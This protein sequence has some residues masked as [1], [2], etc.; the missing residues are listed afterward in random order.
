MP[1]E[2]EVEPPRPGGLKAPLKEREELVHQ[3]ITGSSASSCLRTPLAYGESWD[4][5][6]H[7]CL[8]FEGFCMRSFLA[9]VFFFYG[10]PLVLLVQFAALPGRKVKRRG[11]CRSSRER[12]VRVWT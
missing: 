7:S 9:C 8:R 4:V 5:R 2:V 3:V 6:F 11:G 12:A 1:I 10:G